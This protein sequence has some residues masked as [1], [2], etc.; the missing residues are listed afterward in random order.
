MRH[1]TCRC[2]QLD[3]LRD[4]PWDEVHV[5]IRIDIR[6]DLECLRNDLTASAMTC[7]DAQKSL[8]FFFPLDA[9]VPTV[10]VASL[11]RA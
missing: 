2:R 4:F 7:N 9:D 11:S 5:R 8:L 1:A 3:L 10:G 6:K